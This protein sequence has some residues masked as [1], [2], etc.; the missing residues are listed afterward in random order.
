ML[1]RWSLAIAVSEV[2]AEKLAAGGDQINLFQRKSSFR[3]NPYQF[4]ASS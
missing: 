4:F 2:R 1:D 3:E